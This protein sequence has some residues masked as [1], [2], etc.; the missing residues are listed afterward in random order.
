MDPGNRNPSIKFF[1]R[2]PL[3]NEGIDVTERYGNHLWSALREGPIGGGLMGRDLLDRQTG[4]DCQGYKC[5][6]YEGI[7]I[8]KGLE[9]LTRVL[10]QCGAPEGT[11]IIHGDTEYPVHA[12]PSE[13]G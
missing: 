10:I 1:I 13:R 2:I 6:F 9:T 3:E 7:S 4:T 12:N 8:E 5:H 11:V